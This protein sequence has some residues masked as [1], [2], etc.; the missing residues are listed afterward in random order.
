MLQYLKCSTGLLDSITA[1]TDIS[2]IH[3]LNQFYTMIFVVNLS[4][5]GPHCSS[6]SLHLA[7]IFSLIF[8]SSK[9]VS[10]LEELIEQAQTREGRIIDL[11]QW[12]SDVLGLLQSRLDADLLAGDMPDD[13]QVSTQQIGIVCDT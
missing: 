10:L 7:N 9:R 3:K 12:M 13:Y 1:N 2:Y 6:F 8:Q 5:Y 11:S 4:Y